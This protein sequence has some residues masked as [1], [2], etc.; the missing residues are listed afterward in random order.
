MLRPI[1]SNST[2]TSGLS[3]NINTYRRKPIWRTSK[4]VVGDDEGSLI[5]FKI[6]LLT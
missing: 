3:N 2:L 6:F 4:V 1:S 5:A